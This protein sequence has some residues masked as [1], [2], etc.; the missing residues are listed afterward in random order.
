[1]VQLEGATVAITGGARGIGHATAIEFAHHGAHVVTGDLDR[2][3][4]PG[5]ALEL[6]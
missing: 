4:S 6:D 2:H 3:E 5:V 1:M